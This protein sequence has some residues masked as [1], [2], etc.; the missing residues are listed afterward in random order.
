MKAHR[1]WASAALLLLAA[2]GWLLPWKP[3]L[4]AA[5]RG[6]AAHRETSALAFVALYVLGSGC[7]G[8]RERGGEGKRGDLG[9]RRIIKKKKKRNGRRIGDGLDNIIGVIVGF[10]CRWQRH[11]YAYAVEVV[12]VVET[13]RGVMLVLCDE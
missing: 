4:G 2:A 10:E 11:V 6:A 3:W 7:L 12:R 13:L 5:L 8:D 1:V 9:G